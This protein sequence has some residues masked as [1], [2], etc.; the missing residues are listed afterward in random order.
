MT[1]QFNSLWLPVLLPFTITHI[2]ENV[3]IIIIII[4]IIILTNGV[5]YVYLKNLL[6]LCL[7]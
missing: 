3:I 6:L 1:I 2:L 7:R 5:C 4:I